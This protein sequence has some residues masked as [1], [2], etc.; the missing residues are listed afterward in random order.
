ML[1]RYSKSC[2]SHVRQGQEIIFR[3]Y[4]M[5]ARSEPHTDRHQ[6]KHKDRSSLFFGILKQGQGADA[7]N[8][9]SIA[10]ELLEALLATCIIPRRGG[11]GVG[12]HGEGRHRFFL[13]APG[14]GQQ[15]GGMAPG[16]RRIACE[17]CCQDWTPANSWELSFEGKFRISQ[18]HVIAWDHG[19]ILESIARHPQCMLLLV[20]RAKHN[21]GQPQLPESI[22]SGVGAKLQ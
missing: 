6:S 7:L 12:P 16:G 9:P 14:G 17:H 10:G 2:F 19:R 8:D 11:G 15:D 22:K 5:V 18:N 4:L 21:C 3:V 13:R 1:F 20:G